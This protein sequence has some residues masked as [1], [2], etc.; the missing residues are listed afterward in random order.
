MQKRQAFL[1]QSFSD[2]S[3]VQVLT[4]VPTHPAVLP[5]PVMH[6]LLAF[7]YVPFL[8]RGCHSRNCVIWYYYMFNDIRPPTDLHN[9]DS[10]QIQLINIVHL[11]SPGKQ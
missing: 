1:P 3:P 8:Q 11:N 4:G 2:E 7:L 10:F 9:I 6:N 5:E